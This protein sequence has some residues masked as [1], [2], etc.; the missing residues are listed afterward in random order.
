[1]NQ[2]RFA[3]NSLKGSIHFASSRSTAN[4]GISPTSDRTRN[5]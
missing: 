4:I 2:L 5:F 3:V 1:M